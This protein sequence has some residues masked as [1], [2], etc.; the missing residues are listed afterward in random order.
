MQ[1]KPDNNTNSSTHCIAYCIKLQVLECQSL[2]IQVI[3]ASK[4]YLEQ[5]ITQK[6]GDKNLTSALN[7][8]IWFI[9]WWRWRCDG[10][11]LMKWQRPDDSSGVCCT[12]H[13]ICLEDY[14]F[15]NKASVSPRCC[16][17]NLILLPCNMHER[18]I[19]PSTQSVTVDEPL[20]G[21]R[22]TPPL[23]LPCLCWVNIE[24]VNVGSRGCF[25]SL[26]LWRD[27]LS[28]WHKWL[29]KFCVWL[30]H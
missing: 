13:F 1:Q 16:W 10:E 22:L 4:G 25:F 28:W 14:K 3:Y 5:L 24:V 9:I 19:H 20:A 23:P 2:S 18:I 30:K 12:H 29:L 6:G 21:Q 27:Y 15:C 26:K 8:L 17:L 7:I 11:I